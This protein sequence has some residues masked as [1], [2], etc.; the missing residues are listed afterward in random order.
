MIDV[1]LPPGHVF[2]ERY[3]VE[4]LL[5]RGGFGAVYVAEQLATEAT[6]ALKILWPHILGSEPAVTSFQQEARIAGRVRSPHIVRVLDAGFDAT[7]AMPYLAMELL[8]GE[9][10]EQHVTRVGPLTPEFAVTLLRQLASALDKA[11][12]YVDRE[13]ALRPIVHRDLKPENLFLSRSESGSPLLKVLDF[14]LAKVLSGTSNLSREV[15]GTPLYMA[16]EQVTGSAI[17][18]QTDIWA[19]GLIAFFLLTGTGYWKAGSSADASL[20]QLFAEVITLPIEAPSVRAAE[21]GSRAVLPRGFDE[22]FLRCVNRERTSRFESA[23]RAVAALAETL[24]LAAIADTVIPVTVTASLG[25]NTTSAATAAGASAQGLSITS[26]EIARKRS[27]RP[28]ALVLGALGLIGTL[29]GA[30]LL[31][32][33]HSEPHTDAAVGTAVDAMQQEPPTPVPQDSSALLAVPSPSVV[34]GGGSA[35]TLDAVDAG[36]VASRHPKPQTLSPRRDQ[37][38]ANAARRPREPASPRPPVAPSATPRTP[39][40]YDQR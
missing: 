39:G 2:A 29:A 11:H 18:P 15:K 33:R 10:L 17:T 38:V 14:G 34:V 30:W 22:W 36:A 3:R 4:R 27:A 13:G 31:L 19:L 32:A 21:L 20:T 7:T 6:V 8:E 25:P 16:Y 37:E 1:V 40:V 35:A 26:A 5:A 9:D 24:G 12:G 23:G 28:L